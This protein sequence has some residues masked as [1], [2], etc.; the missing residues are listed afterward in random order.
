MNTKSQVNYLPVLIPEAV[1]FSPE[2]VAKYLTLH[3]QI[4][5]IFA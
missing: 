4:L 1:C 5:E 3:Q 2:L